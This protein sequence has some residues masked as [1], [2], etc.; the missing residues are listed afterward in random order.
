[1][2]FYRNVQEKYREASLR[3]GLKAGDLTEDDVRLIKTFVNEKQAANNWKEHRVQKSTMDLRQWRRFIKKPY[4]ECGID[5]IYSG[6][7]ALKNG[8]SQRG[9]PFSQNT[10][11]D[12]I[13]VLKW[14]L[15]W[16]IE[17]GHFTLPKDKISGLKI[18]AQNTHTTIPEQLLT[19]D[20]IKTLI[21]A[22][23]GSQYP[24]RDQALI[25]VLFESGCRIGELSS[26]C[27]RHV[28]PTEYGFGLTIEAKKTKNQRYTGLVMAAPYLAIWKND[29]PSVIQPDK[30]VFIAMWDRIHSKRS[31]NGQSEKASQSYAPLEYS[32][33]VALLQRIVRR[34][35]L[36]KRV[37]CHLFR[38]SRI[39]DMIRHNYQ[40]SIIKQVA[41]GNTNTKQFQTYVVLAPT[42]VDAEI[43]ERTGIKPKKETSHENPLTPKICS[44]CKTV[45]PVTSVYCGICAR[46]LTEEAALELQTAEIEIRND[47]RYKAILDLLSDPK[48]VKTLLES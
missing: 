20:D 3:N 47:P 22:A 6:I 34:T 45:N 4:R 25:A 10:I 2:K 41:W 43:M 42:D 24:S 7:N 14:F 31:Q 18:P 15:K 9:T 32:A 38:K 13:K 27:W 8:N 11:H 19:A 48:K 23:K 17:N 1:M 29:Y 28:T 39:T 5:D 12:Y 26:L 46:P 21:E 33:I 35:H 16:G 37:H 44:W 30:P 36:E 40:E